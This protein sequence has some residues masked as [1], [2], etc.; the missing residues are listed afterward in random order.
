MARFREYSYEQTVMLRV[1]L[2]RHL[3][4]GSFERFTSP[5]PALTRARLRPPAHG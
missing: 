5:P 3:Q 2:G 4:P 1:A